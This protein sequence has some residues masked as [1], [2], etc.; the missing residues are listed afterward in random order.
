MDFPPFHLDA[1]GNRILIALIAIIHV[2]INHG[3]AIGAAP[4]ITGIEY[5]AYKTKNASLDKLAY[6][7]LFIVFVITT[8]LGALTGVG[9]WLSTSLVSPY[10]IG[11]LIRV[12]FWA[13][14]T[15]WIV[16]ITEVSLIMAYF[17]TWRKVKTDKQKV[18]HIR[19][20]VALSI[21][22]WITMSII[23][24]ILGFMGDSG[25][26]TETRE[27]WTAIFNPLYLSQLA[28]RTPIAMIS[29]AV[30]CIF[31][32]SI[33]ARKKEDAQIR[34]DVVRGT[35]V[36]IIFLIPF[37]VMGGY[38]MYI[39]LPYYM[40]G[41]IQVGLLTTKFLDWLDIFCAIMVASFAVCML[42]HQIA[43]LKP[44]WINTWILII[45]V[46]LNIAVLS[47]FERVREFSRK[48]YVIGKYMY[49]NSIIAD[50]YPLLQSEGLLANSTYRMLL[51]EDESAGLENGSEI[52][53]KVEDGKNVFFMSCSRCHGIRGQNAL[54]D[55]FETM[56][57]SEDWDPD[58]IAT[59]SLNAHDMQKFMPPFAGTVE[60]AD[61][62]GLYIVQMHKTNAPMYGVQSVGIAIE[63]TGG[64]RKPIFAVSPH[65][66]NG[67]DAGGSNGLV[68]GGSDGNAVVASSIVGESVKKVAAG[69]GDLIEGVD[70]SDSSGLH[71]VH[72][73]HGVYDVHGVY[74]AHGLHGGKIH[75]NDAAVKNASSAGYA[76]AG[77]GVVNNA[78][79]STDENVVA[80]DDVANFDS[81]KNV[82]AKND[83]SKQ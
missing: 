31:F 5:A 67:S 30:C 66:V 39:S 62:L 71:G 77:D 69:G 72:D 25:N 37:A 75:D 81:S 4:V 57:D 41:N 10:S 3:F 42:I 46:V 14:V 2:I 45:P 76:D 13:W 26:W 74:D 21:C 83:F 52:F 79:M 16:F 44:R 22:S 64:S 12:F 55:I 73:A 56:S 27:F 34:S 9:L 18:N 50:D 32:A 43:V 68:S 78:G 7:L 49:A 29:G 53:N 38:W 8:S 17:L 23:V 20:G 15:E 47:Y 40:S 36:W 28:F 80:I 1:M 63:K 33:F 61:N 11:S 19:L 70:S 58:M 65:L 51:T 54:L 35:S 48:P 60:D 6:K 59:Y 24:A 82:V